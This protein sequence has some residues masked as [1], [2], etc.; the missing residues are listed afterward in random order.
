MTYDLYDMHCHLGFMSNAPEV[1]HDAKALGLAVF[2][3]TVTP[4]E[5]EILCH[6]LGPNPNVRVGIGLHPWWVADGRCGS[7]QLERAYELVHTTRYI[8][9]IGLDLSPRHVPKGSE[10]IQ[11]AAFETI[12]GICGETSDPEARKV[13]SIH[14]VRSANLALD[15]LERTN[16]LATCHCIFHWFS[17]TSDELHRAVKAGCWFSI[18]EMMLRT[19]RGRE[20]A[21]QIPNSRLLTETDLPPTEGEAFSATEVV[22]SLE[23]TLAQLEEFCAKDVRSVVAHNARALLEG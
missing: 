15:I 21:R 7:E 8:G 16:C 18:N 13:L 22:S 9:E 1:L 14:S 19:R 12:T 23:R 20:Y 3:N 5:Y 6:Q 11:V 10:Q 2:A 17:G 4:G